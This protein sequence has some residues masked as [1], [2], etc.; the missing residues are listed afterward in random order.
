MTYRRWADS[1]PDSFRVSVKMP[2]A[3]THKLR[4]PTAYF[5]CFERAPMSPSCAGRGMVRPSRMP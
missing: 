2:R 5:P 3:V 1:V 4:L